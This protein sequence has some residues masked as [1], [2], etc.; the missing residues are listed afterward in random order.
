MA[1][2]I[3]AKAVFTCNHIHNHD[4]DDDDDRLV[5]SGDHGDDDD[6][7]DGGDLLHGKPGRSLGGDRPVRDESGKERVDCVRQLGSRTDVTW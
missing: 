5:T 3:K 4:N 7:D 1:G 2:T 6:D